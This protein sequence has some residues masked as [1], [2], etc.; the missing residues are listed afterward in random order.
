MRI[1][2]GQ[3]RGRRLRGPKS[4]AVRPTSDRVREALF[5]RINAWLP[6]AVVLDLFAGTGALGLEAL[7]RGALRAVFVERDPRALAL[8]RDNIS[9]CGVGRRSR[10]VA[11]TVS[12]AL[13]RL[14]EDRCQFDLV[15]MDPPYGK[16]HVRR[17][18]PILVGVTGEGSQLVIEHR[19]S[20]DW[21]TVP[22][23]WKVK[24]AT[25]Y[26]DTMITLLWR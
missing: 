14:S 1:I 4:R 2:A 12:A 5:S 7:S 11:A 25:R 24:N 22:E 21:G 10:V 18:L 16:D 17:V 6:D 23:P 8:I 3:F 13:H 9:A 20:D 26:G 15:F 19:T